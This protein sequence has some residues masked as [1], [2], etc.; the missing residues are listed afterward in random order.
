MINVNVATSLGSINK[1]QSKYTK[2]DLQFNGRCQAV[3]NLSC[4]GLR[5]QTV[6]HWTFRVFLQ[7]DIADSARP[8]S[9]PYFG[10]QPLNTFLPVQHML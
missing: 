5:R 3:L 9:V 6:L 4:N 10:R 7:A 2:P 8:L 1:V